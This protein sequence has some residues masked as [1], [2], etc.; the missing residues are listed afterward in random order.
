[1]RAMIPPSAYIIT[2][3]YAGPQPGAPAPGQPINQLVRVE[4]MSDGIETVLIDKAERT[5]A[6]FCYLLV[7]QIIISCGPDYTKCHRR[8]MCRT[9][10]RSGCSNP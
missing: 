10:L 8:Y 9:A 7:V 6:D 3:R 5:G 2:N 4:R 1:M